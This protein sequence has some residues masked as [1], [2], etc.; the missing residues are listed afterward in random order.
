MLKDLSHNLTNKQA[1]YL[2]KVFIK[3]SDMRT[4]MARKEDRDRAN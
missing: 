1:Q 4:E 2:Q 3:A